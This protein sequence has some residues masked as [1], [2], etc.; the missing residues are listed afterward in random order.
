VRLPVELLDGFVSANLEE[1][2]LGAVDDPN[3][4]NLV[5]LGTL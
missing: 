1:L 5:D 2:D 4:I 3:E